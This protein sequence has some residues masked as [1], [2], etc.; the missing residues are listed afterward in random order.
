MAEQK[1][2]CVAEMSSDREYFLSSLTDEDR[3]RITDEYNLRLKYHQ[4]LVAENCLLTDNFEKSTKHEIFYSE[5]GI[6]E[7]LLKQDQFYKMKY[8]LFNYCYCHIDDYPEKIEELWTKYPVVTT[9]LS[10]T[11]VV[12]SD[13]KQCCHEFIELDKKI[14]QKLGNENDGFHLTINEFRQIEMLNIEQMKSVLEH[15]NIGDFS[16]SNFRIPT[17]DD[18]VDKM[19]ENEDEDEDDSKS[20]HINLIFQRQKSL[21]DSVPT[22]LEKMKKFHHAINWDIMFLAG[23]ACTSAILGTYINDF[24]FYLITDDP[25]KANNQLRALAKIEGKGVQLDGI[26]RSQ[27][28]VTFYFDGV[29]IQVILRLYSDRQQVLLG[30]DLDSCCCGFDGTKFVYT[31][32][33]YNAMMTNTNIVDPERQSLTYAYRLKKYSSRGF[34]VA[35]PGIV[36]DDIYKFLKTPDTYSGVGKIIAM[37]NRHIT[38]ADKINYNLFQQSD[39]DTTFSDRGCFLSNVNYVIT[40][41]DDDEKSSITIENIHSSLDVENILD[42]DEGEIKVK[43][44]SN[45]NE[46]KDVNINGK[47]VNRLIKVP[48]EIVA[49]N[50]RHLSYLGNVPRRIQYLT[51]LPHSQVSGSFHPTTEDWYKNMN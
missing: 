12:G 40:K 41:L 39:Y 34:A 24:D 3:F 50:N 48:D 1:S 23:G 22:L 16:I 21:F 33:F 44:F 19:R 20:N 18:V 38:L 7:Y 45:R 25:E 10:K 2:V 28:S 36:Y 14:Y 37:L 32:R 27:N 6:R 17:I 42:I 4:G 8:D 49:I 26:T 30:F 35:I 13:V 15:L 47:I 9:Y 43:L 46:Y 31:P 5:L 11:S 51:K 29:K